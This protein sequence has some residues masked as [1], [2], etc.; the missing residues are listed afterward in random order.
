MKNFITGILK[1]II[2]G[3]LAVICILIILSIVLYDKIALTRVIPE[4]EQYFLSDEM[5]QE[6][7]DYNIPTRWRN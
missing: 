1:D 2:I 6:I 5:Q 4:T 7:E 3:V